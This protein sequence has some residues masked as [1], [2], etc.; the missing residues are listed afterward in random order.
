MSIY[1]YELN[2]LFGKIK[3]ELAH[4]CD[5]KKKLDECHTRTIE[6]V[7]ELLDRNPITELDKVALLK[8]IDELTKE[9]EET[10]KSVARYED[11]AR[12]WMNSVHELNKDKET[13]TT[14]VNALAKVVVNGIEV[15]VKQ[16]GES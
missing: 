15:V 2:T 1:K 14:V 10:K 13:L 9:L 5:I 3:Y 6:I 12:G 7:Q 8:R 4:E 11:R 16:G